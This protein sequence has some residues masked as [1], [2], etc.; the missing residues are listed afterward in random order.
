AR[1]RRKPRHSLIAQG[2]PL[3]WLTGGALAVSLAMILL[4]LFTVFWHGLQTLWPAPIAQ[5]RLLTGKVYL[6][7][8]TRSEEYRPA[9]HV[10]AALPPA[11]AKQAREY[12]EQNGGIAHRRLLRTEN[13]ELTN[14]HFHWIDDFLVK[15]ETFPAEAVLI[16][17]EMNGRFYGFPVA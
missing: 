10:F 2:E 14:S 8:F 12:I 3:I 5:V 1:P 11:I 16:E 9:E 6:G 15:E 13:F 7:E 4:L 17:R